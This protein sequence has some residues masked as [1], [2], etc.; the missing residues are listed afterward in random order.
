MTAERLR[1]WA[2][3][4]RRAARSAAA[5]ARSSGLRSGDLEWRRGTCCP[6]IVAGRAVGCAETGS[7]LVGREQ[8]RD[9]LAAVV[10]DHAQLA[11]DGDH[12]AL[13]VHVGRLEGHRF[14]LAG[15]HQRELVGLLLVDG[16]I[17]HGR[18]HRLEELVLPIA[19]E[20]GERRVELAELALEA[21]DREGLRDVVE[22][23]ARLA[24]RDRLDR[25]VAL[26]AQL[27]ELGAARDR[28]GGAARPAGACSEADD[29]AEY[30]GD[31]LVVLLALGGRRLLGALGLAAGDDRCLPGGGQARLE[32]VERRER[33]GELGLSPSIR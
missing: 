11:V 22:A 30:L 18:P 33:E 12:Q 1:R 10:A 4:P 16:T 32:L 15:R 28:A 14:E 13:R 23:M 26:G 21:E 24:R 20:L 8:Q 5:R 7:A 6:R 9:G 29:L 3:S 17:V 25:A 27:A 19:D 31:A 2:V